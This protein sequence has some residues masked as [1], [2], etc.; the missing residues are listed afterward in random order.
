MELISI[1][2]MMEIDLSKVTKRVPIM[3]EQLMAAVLFI[4][5]YK[6]M[7]HHSHEDVDELHY[8]IKGR[9]DIII[10]D[11]TE[12]MY[13]G[14]LVLVP[15]GRSH[16]FLASDEGLVILAVSPVSLPIS[17]NDGMIQKR[18]QAR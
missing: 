10:D 9:G 6:E 16:H 7:P 1:P 18:D 15:K 3:T 12:P 17:L 2:D 14:K 4:G 11:E 13:E 5:P 8:V